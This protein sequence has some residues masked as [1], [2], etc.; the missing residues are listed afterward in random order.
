MTGNT[1]ADKAFITVDFE[2]GRQHWS[3]DSQRWTSPSNA[4]SP[5]IQA[6]TSKRR[7]T[8]AI[9][10]TCYAMSIRHTVYLSFNLI[11]GSATNHSSNLKFQSGCELKLET[12]LLL[13]STRCISQ[14]E[15]EKEPYQKECL[16][17]IFIEETCMK[18]TSRLTETGQIP[19]IAACIV[20]SLTW[21]SI[22]SNTNVT[23]EL[24][25]I[26]HLLL[27]GNHLLD[28]IWMH[29]FIDDSH[30]VHHHIPHLHWMGKTALWY[31]QSYSMWLKPVHWLN[32]IHITKMTWADTSTTLISQKKK[33]WP[34]ALGYSPLA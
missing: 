23:W 29:T 10:N 2:F 30:C 28:S 22:R 12:R 31:S 13:D 5:Q 16:V 6:M 9:G 11:A 15:Q 3:V 4:D 20:Y 1:K 8:R 34:A 33:K 32:Y 18:N 19:V 26:H 17:L 25:L 27:L 7:E 24:W 14:H 21:W